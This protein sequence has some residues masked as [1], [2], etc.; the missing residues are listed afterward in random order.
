[1]S[2]KLVY[3]NAT[4][5][6]P[7]VGTL[8]SLFDAIDRGVNIRIGL[9]DWDGSNMA[10]LRWNTESV[11]YNKQRTLAIA[12]FPVHASNL[13]YSENGVVTVA[14]SDPSHKPPVCVIRSDGVEHMFQSGV[15]YFK[16]DPAKD[17][18]QYQ[19]FADL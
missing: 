14:P 8:E 16:S 6:K 13:N 18:R 15:E 2:W 11:R 9:D 7:M 3:A 12:A 1:M 19:W 5:S 17:D 4:R 10:S